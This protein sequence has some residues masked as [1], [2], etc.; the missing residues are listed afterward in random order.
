[1]KHVKLFSKVDR[2]GFRNRVRKLLKNSQICELFNLK[3]YICNEE[4][5]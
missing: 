4:E 5:I 1:M 2:F 3:Y